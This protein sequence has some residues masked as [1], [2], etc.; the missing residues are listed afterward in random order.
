M[1]GQRPGHIQDE[2]QKRFRLD[3]DH[4]REVLVVLV[5]PE[6]NKRQHED[7]LGNDLRQGRGNPGDDKIAG[8]ERQVGTMALHGSHRQDRPRSFSA[9]RI[10]G[11]LFFP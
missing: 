4:P 3:I 1:M 6:G 8:I 5:E 2:A 9:S 11:Q 10:S 7:F